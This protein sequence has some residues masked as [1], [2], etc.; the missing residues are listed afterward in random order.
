MIKYDLEKQATLLFEENVIPLTRQNWQELLRL[1]VKSTY[2]HIITGDANE[3]HS[4]WV[5]R[6]I[7]DVASPLAL[8]EFSKEIEAIVMSASMRAFYKQFIGT[9]KIC[10]RRCQANRMCEGDYIGEHKDQDSSPDYIATI[11]FHFSN[12]YTGGYFLTSNTDVGYSEE[13]RYKPGAR[14][15]LVN[16]CSIAHQVTKVE[17]GERLTLACFL[18]TSF[19]ANTISPSEFKLGKSDAYD[20]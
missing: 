20:G 8:N 10:L 13:K 2:Q 7:N 16:N 14:M 15:A 12:D 11:V 5:S 1:L 9:D 17:R 18:S 4:V 19:S 6:Y 3:N